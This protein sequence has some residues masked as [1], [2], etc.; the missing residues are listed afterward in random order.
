M[1][2]G[3]TIVERVA[4]RLRQVRWE[5]SGVS[6][7]M[8]D[9]LPLLPTELYEAGVAIEEAMSALNEAENQR[10]KLMAIEAALQLARK[11][12][13]LPNRSTLRP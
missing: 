10:D 6:H 11:I 9:S 7:E 4:R 1:G 3:V 5:R 8:S 12:H 2:S 13:V